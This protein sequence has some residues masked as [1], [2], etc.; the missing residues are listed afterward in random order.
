MQDLDKALGDNE[1]ITS[2]DFAFGFIVGTV[3]VF[4]MIFAL[5]IMKRA[6]NLIYEN[7]ISFL[8]PII[9]FVICIILIGGAFRLKRDNIAY[10]IITAIFSI[11]VIL[12]MIWFLVFLIKAS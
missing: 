10:G 11:P 5:F 1:R 3:M 12:F 4:L 9:L 8:A 7:Y 2:E 6:Y